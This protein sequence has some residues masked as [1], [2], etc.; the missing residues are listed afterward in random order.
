MELLKKELVAKC[1]STNFEENRNY[2]YKFFEEQNGTQ[3]NEKIKSIKCGVYYLFDGYLNVDVGSRQPVRDF[4][5]TNTTL[6]QDLTINN[7]FKLNANEINNL[8]NPTHATILYNFTYENRRYI[9]YSN[10]GL[11][12]EKNQY[13][14]NKLVAPKIYYVRDEFLHK[15]IP[16]YVKKLYMLIYELSIPNESTTDS[17]K[18]KIDEMNKEILKFLRTFRHKFG[19]LENSLLLNVGIL[20]MLKSYIFPVEKLQLKYGLNLES[21]KHVKE[22]KELLQDIIY[23]ILNY[24]VYL[25][26]EVE[27]CTFNHILNGSDKDEVKEILNKFSKNTENDSKDLASFFKNTQQYNNDIWKELMGEGDAN[28]DGEITFEEFK[29]MMKKMLHK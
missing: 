6:E 19:K 24:V 12:I 25:F 27:E 22:N 7:L 18:L 20:H 8:P 1:L 15:F 5:M 17:L 11:G 10:S 23:A 28:D 29:H 21:L 2:L 26:D 4:I 9:Y 16:E 3:H 14:T 13:Y